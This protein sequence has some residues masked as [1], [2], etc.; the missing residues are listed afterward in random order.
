[1]SLVDRLL[2]A[3]P[4]VHTAYVLAELRVAAG[5][6]HN[7]VGVS[8]QRVGIYSERTPSTT[9]LDTIHA[10]LHRE[11]GA[12]FQEART[13]A[14]AWVAWRLPGVRIGP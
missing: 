14:A 3:P 11:T 7:Q 9:G 4:P 2:G 1:M 12:T 6:C 8:A 13:K 5:H 10:E